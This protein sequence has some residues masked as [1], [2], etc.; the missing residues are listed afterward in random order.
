MHT[1]KDIWSL[2]RVHTHGKGATWRKPV[3]LG[4]QCVSLENPLPCVLGSGRTAKRRSTANEW[5]HGN[6]RAHGS[7]GAHGSVWSHGSVGAH[8]NV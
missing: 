6:E 7:V 5:A 2:C 3:L 1:A 8:G 4:S